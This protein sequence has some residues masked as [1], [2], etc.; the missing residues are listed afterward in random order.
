MS[1]SEIC[2][3]HRRRN[4]M[5]QKQIA[6]IIHLDISNVSRFESGSNNSLDVFIRYIQIFPGI[7]EDV[8][9]AIKAGENVTR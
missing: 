1:I 3:S 8:Y 6:N 5:T 7:V 2:R 9:E 4:S